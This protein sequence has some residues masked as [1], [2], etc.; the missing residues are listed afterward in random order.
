MDAYPTLAIVLHLHSKRQQ[1][2]RA[3]E[4]KQSGNGAGKAGGR[5]QAPMTLSRALRIFERVADP[6]EDRRRC[7]C[8][9]TK[10]GSQAADAFKKATK[11][12]SVSE[13]VERSKRF[14]RELYDG[15]DTD[16]F[17]K[18]YRNLAL[19]YHPDKNGKGA[20]Q[21]AEQI[22]QQLAAAHNILNQKKKQPA[23]RDERILGTVPVC[24][25]PLRCSRCA[26]ARWEFR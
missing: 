26:S 19:K 20:K 1:A 2:V 16:N 13:K 25:S 21:K 9:R 8:R 4:C 14:L 15:K 3:R 22:F 18:M 7:H 17:R 23:R 6:R 12:K 5:Q 24:S 11:D 10:S